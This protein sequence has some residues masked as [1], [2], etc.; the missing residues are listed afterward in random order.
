MY[1]KAQKCKRWTFLAIL[2]RFPDRN[3]GTIV[4]FFPHLEAPLNNTGSLFGFPLFSFTDWG[5]PVTALIN[6]QK[7]GTGWRM[8][9]RFP[10][11]LYLPNNSLPFSYPLI[12]LH[13]S[14]FNAD[15]SQSSILGPTIF[16]LTNLTLAT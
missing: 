16:L 7:N 4:H 13:N 10:R 14:I 5:I 15:V 12:I 9:S 6:S 11:S 1:F 8:V 3:Q 2:S